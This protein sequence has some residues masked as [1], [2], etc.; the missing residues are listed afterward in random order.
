MP[1][2]VWQG[3]TPYETFQPI[4]GLDY[5]SQTWVNA[6]TGDPGRA[7]DPN[8]N[9]HHSR[10]TTPASMAGLN[11]LGGGQGYWNRVRNNPFMAEARYRNPMPVPAAGG[12]PG[13][14]SD[15]GG[16]TGGTD[17]FGQFLVRDDLAEVADHSIDWKA[18]RTSNRKEYKARKKQAER[19]IAHETA[20]DERL[21]NLDE[22]ARQGKGVRPGEGRPHFYEY[23][24]TKEYAEGARRWLRNERKRYRGWNAVETFFD[25]PL[26]AI[27]SWF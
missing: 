3:S 24:A 16:Y 26:G 15:Q 6:P 25:D 11:I 17:E 18:A 1:T 8:V 10:A 14:P 5:V 13:R 4:E 27:S 9:P 12:V 2:V 21:E 20:M 19:L 23:T 22:L 7:L